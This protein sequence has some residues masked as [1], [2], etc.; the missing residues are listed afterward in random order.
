[1]VGMICVFDFGFCVLD[2]VLRVVVWQL[3]V[4]VGLVVFL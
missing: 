2:C 1:M 4:V 3:F